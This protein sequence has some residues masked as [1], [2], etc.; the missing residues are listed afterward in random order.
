MLF[1]KA[2]MKNCLYM[3]DALEGFCG[4]SRQ[5]INKEKSKAYFSPNVVISDREGLCG[6][7]GIWSMPKLGKYL[8][9]PLKQP[10]SSSAGTLTL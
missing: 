4:V 3:M 10:G 2:N 1:A 7:L 9:F 6:V 5:K 8:S